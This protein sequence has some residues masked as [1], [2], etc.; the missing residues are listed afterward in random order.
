MHEHSTSDLILVRF[1]VFFSLLYTKIKEWLE[2]LIKQ[3]NYVSFVVIK[4]KVCKGNDGNIFI[5]PKNLAEIDSGDFCFCFFSIIGINF[6]VLTC[7][8]CKAFFR[9]NALRK[10]V[11]S[12]RLILV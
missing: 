2:K 4:L 5:F 11:S 7:M 3:S 1:C 6:N 8:S 10:K 9:R 12:N